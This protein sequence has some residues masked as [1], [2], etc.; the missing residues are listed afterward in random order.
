M[1]SG[2]PRFVAQLAD[3]RGNVVDLDI[4]VESGLLARRAILEVTASHGQHLGIG[5]L[6]ARTPRNGLAHYRVR[7]LELPAR[8]AHLFA[9]LRAGPERMVEIVNVM[10]ALDVEETFA[11]KRPLVID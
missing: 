3:R 8:T 11:A 1:K 6:P 9:A 10:H 2:Q 5:E 4:W 7:G